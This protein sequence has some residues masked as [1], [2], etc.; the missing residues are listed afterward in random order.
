MSR[1]VRSLASAVSLGA[2][3]ALVGACHPPT[4]IIIEPKQPVLH[5][6]GETIRLVPHVMAGRYEDAQ[7][8]VKWSSDVPEIASVGADGTVTA[9]ATGTATVTAAC[10]GIKGLVH[11]EVAVTDKM[12]S[13]DKVELKYDSDD[14][15]DPKVVVATSQGEVLKLAPNLRSA[16]DKVCRVDGRGQIRAGSKGDTVLTV[17]LDG[18]TINIPCSVKD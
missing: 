2:V 4:N 14:A 8:V 6:R 5:K 10:D 7:A 16:D 1:V 9:K 15:F 12:T 11:V 17:T 3:V 18:K 13:V